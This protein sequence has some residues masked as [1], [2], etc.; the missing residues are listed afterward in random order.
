METIVYYTCSYVPPEILMAAGFHPERLLPEA[1][2][3]EGDSH[4]HPASCCFCKSLVADALDTART[5]S[6]QRVVFTSCCDGMRKAFDIVSRY[7]PDIKAL[8]LDVPKEKNTGSI[9]FFA[10]TLKSFA[11]D[12]E[13][14]FGGRAVDTKNLNQAIHEY[15]ELRVQMNKFFSSQ[16]KT[17]TSVSGRDYFR[18]LID[19]ASG[20]LKG[21]VGD[22]AFPVGDAGGVGKTRIVVAGNMLSRPELVDCIGECGAAVVAIDS[23]MGVRFFD[24]QVAE[25]T[26]DPYASLS[27]RY[28][29][30][31]SCPRMQGTEERIGFLTELAR[32]AKADGIIY[33]SVKY[34]DNTILEIPLLTRGA[35]DAGIPFLFIENEYEWTNMEPVRTRVAAFLE[36]IRA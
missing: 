24:M 19:A 26:A 20:G 5:G 6:G 32:T 16:Q 22:S 36:M 4:M 13:K 23:C 11:R 7:R 35:R 12:V 8:M 34:C 30:R 15:N 18:L 9:A 28:L 27:E 3:S 25:N 10:S 2:P 14:E 29:K 21:K 17:G 31:A 1:R 33:T